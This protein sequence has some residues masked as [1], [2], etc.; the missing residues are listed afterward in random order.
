MAMSCAHDPPLKETTKDLKSPHNTRDKKIYW[1]IVILFIISILVLSIAD[2]VYYLWQIKHSHLEKATMK[3]DPVESDAQLA[4]N[5]KFLYT[6]YLHSFDVYDGH[7]RMLY[8]ERTHA[9]SKLVGDIFAKVKKPPVTADAHLSQS[10]IIFDLQ[11]TNYAQV[12]L[13]FWDLHFGGTKGST[14][15]VDCSATIALTLYRFLPFTFHLSFAR[16]LALGDEP[17]ERR[18]L[19]P[20]STLRRFIDSVAQTL[21]D[22]YLTTSFEILSTSPSQITV[23]VHKELPPIETALYFRHMKSFIVQIPSLAFSIDTVDGNVTSTLLISNT[24]IELEILNASALNAKTVLSLN[25]VPLSSANCSLL[26]GLNLEKFFNDLRFGRIFLQAD[27]SPD[28]ALGVRGNFLSNFLGQRHRIQVQPALTN[29][30]GTADL[31]DGANCYLATVDSA[32]ESLMCVEVDKGFLMYLQ[33][34][35][36]SGVIATV[37]SF[38]SRETFGQLAFDADFEAYFR[39]GYSV[40]ANLSTSMDFKNASTVFGFYENSRRLL[41]GNTFTSWSFNN[42]RSFG[43]LFMTLNIV[44]DTATRDELVTEWL[45]RYGDNKYHM[46]L[47]QHVLNP[48][49][50]KIAAEGFGRYGGTWSHWCDVLPHFRH[51]H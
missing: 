31:S 23:A 12:R 37:K 49:T 47:L 48:V 32:M 42:S 27:S 8:S 10:Q 20:H 50:F 51:L 26:T 19:T 1:K 16:S 43:D 3:L 39:G 41:H 4:L 21:S 22:I 18:K 11:N 17:S 15:D 30:H 7:C 2:I 6:S 46:K 38:N 45:F 40:I 28:Y 29:H 35:D 34:A 5:S 25:C 13:L 14:L 44:D 36:D 33:I 9:S 24:L